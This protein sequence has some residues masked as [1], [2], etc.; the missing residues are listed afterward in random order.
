MNFRNLLNQLIN[1]ENKA[2]AMGIQAFILK[3]ILTQE[4]AETIR[5]VLDGT[6]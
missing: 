1:S 5:R 2:K 4:L 3:P 6:R